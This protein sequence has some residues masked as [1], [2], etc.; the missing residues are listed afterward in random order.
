[1]NARSDT[2]TL[3]ARFGQPLAAVLDTLTALLAEQ[4]GRLRAQQPRSAPADF[5]A[6]RV[7]FEHHSGAV[8]KVLKQTLLE[9]WPEIPF[10]DKELESGTRQ[11]P[12]YADAYW[13]CDP[14]D[15]ALHYLSGMP[16]WTIALCLV[17]QGKPALS[18]VH[19]PATGRT[20][21][22]VAGQGADCDGQPL[23]VNARGRLAPAMIATAHP[24][25]PGQVRED[26][27]DFLS[28]F[29]RLLPQVFGLRVHGPTSL[30]LAL[31]AGGAID[32]YWECG[33]DYYDWLP[34]ALLVSE[35]G[36][37]VTALD[38]KPFGWGCQGIV[39]AGPA[40][41]GVLGAALKGED[42]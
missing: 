12:E 10:S 7:G 21:R 37:T 27:A 16:G 41:H 34:G 11:A 25:W 36:G 35:A 24:N 32:G 42:A 30:L 39:A 28:R 17:V 2:P 6:L 31:V 33:Q 40:M 29:G 38:G 8:G 22:A 1:M 5:E 13:V 18:L 23:R 9:R 26:T 19:D 3:P 15:G 4:G 20:Y 14:I